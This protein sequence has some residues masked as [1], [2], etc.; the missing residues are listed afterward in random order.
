MLKGL[1]S[2]P[3]VALLGIFFLLV[4]AWFF[5]IV[6]GLRDFQW[7]RMARFPRTHSTRLTAL[8]ILIYLVFLFFWLPQNTFY[9]LFYLPA[10]ILLLADLFNHWRGHSLTTRYRLALFVAIMAIANF[11]FFIYPYSYS[12]KYPVL[13]A[14]LE[15]KKIW[16]PDAIVYY[17]S[18]NS[19]N[20]LVQYVNP[21]TSWRTLLAMKSLDAELQQANLSGQ[22]SWLDASAI[23]QLQ[24]T[25]EGAD[26]LARH[27]RPETLHEKRDRGANLKFIKIVP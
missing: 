1:L 15:M 20:S 22:E 11:L 9:R 27:A 6:R 5:L 21:A 13:A 23:D 25:P 17:A 14:A 18:Q 12:E 8:W 3:I 19:D 2:P 16:K 10:I 24:K 26:W 4:A 7:Q